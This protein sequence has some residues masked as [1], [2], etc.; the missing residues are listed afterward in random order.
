MENRVSGYYFE[1]YSGLGT[2]G[3]PPEHVH[4]IV[5]QGHH[6][7]VHEEC[8]YKEGIGEG[9]AGLQWIEREIKEPESNFYLTIDSCQ[10]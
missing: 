8:V 3:V 7:Y 1:E 9:F 10:Q 4:Q 6:I 2:T 5:C